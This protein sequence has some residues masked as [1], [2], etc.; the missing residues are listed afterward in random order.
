MEKWTRFHISCVG[1]PRIAPDFVED[2][3]APLRR[4][5]ERLPRA[6]AGRVPEGRRRHRD[7]VRAHRAG[8]QARRAAASREADLGRRLRAVRLDASS[9]A[10][11]RGQHAGLPTEIRKGYDTMQLV[12]WV[13][14][15][16]IATLPSERPSEILVDVDRHR[17]RRARSAVRARAAGARDQRVGVAAMSEQYLNLRAELWFKGREW[18]AK[19]DCNIAERRDARRGARAAAVQ[20]HLERQAPGRVEGRHEEARRPSPNRADAFLL[21]LAG[22]SITASEGSSHAHRVDEATASSLKS[23]V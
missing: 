1:H 23:I 10:S 14:A 13:K 17:R 21:T 15:S 7:P 16:G 11:R 22:E 8:A 18:F 6:R 12:G 2:M 9:L 19:K 4:G 20:V 3:K 5:V